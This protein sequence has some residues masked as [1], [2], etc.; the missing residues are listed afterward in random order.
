MNHAFNE[1]IFLLFLFK[2][3]RSIIFVYHDLCITQ[4][5]GYLLG[6]RQSYQSGNSGID[7]YS[8]AFLIPSINTF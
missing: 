8:V 4:N 2:T 5:S 6:I 7:E 1:I 3:M